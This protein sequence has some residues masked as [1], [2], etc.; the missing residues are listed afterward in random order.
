MMTQEAFDLLDEVYG[1]VPEQD[2]ENGCTY[3]WVCNYSGGRFYTQV[4]EDHIWLNNGI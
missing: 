4:V 1:L 2:L 3:Q